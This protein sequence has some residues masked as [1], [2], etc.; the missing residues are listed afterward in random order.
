M[1]TRWI[2]APKIHILCKLL[3][4]TSSFSSSSYWL[5]I[6]LYL[7]THQARKL[8]PPNPQMISPWLDY[9]KVGFVGAWTS[10][11]TITAW[12]MSTK[13]ERGRV[14]YSPFSRISQHLEEYSQLSQVFPKHQSRSPF[15]FS[16]KTIG[17]GR[18]CCI[19]CFWARSHCRLTI[20]RIC[21]CKWTKMKRICKVENAGQRG[22]ATGIDLTC[23]TE[24]LSGIWIRKLLPL[25][26]VAGTLL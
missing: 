5:T 8:S 12:S 24:V 25:L 19:C 18:I 15:S 14:P 26:T 1:S 17:V 20:R 16:A 10:T 13:N 6:N 22:T 23:E 21:L 4:W 7:S 9:V 2:L 11:M 3:I